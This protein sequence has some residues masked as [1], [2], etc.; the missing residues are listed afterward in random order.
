MKDDSL[1]NRPLI[2]AP[3]GGKASFLGALAAEADAIYCGL[4]HFSARMAAENFTVPELGRLAALAKSRGVRVYIALNTLV[5]P[6][7]IGKAGQLVDQ[8]NR[9]VKPDALIVQ[10]IAFV[11]LAR[12]AGYEGEIHLS[13]LTNVTFPKALSW[14]KKKLNVHRV[15]LPRELSVDEIKAMTAACPSG[16]SVEVFVHGALCYGISGR[17]Y[18]SS[19]LGGKSGLRGRCV[20][21]CRRAYNVGGQKKRYFSCQDFSLDVLAK[22]LLSEKSISAW[23]IEG[24]KKGPHYVFT[25]TQAYR[26][27]RDHAGEPDAKK[28][29]LA[30]LEQ[31]LGRTG[32]HYQ[33]LPQRPQNPVDTSSQTG[34]GLMVGT[35]K[36]GRQSPY[37]KPNVNLLAGDM[38]RLGYEDQEFH[39]TYRVTKSVPRRGN[40]AIRMPA[41]RMPTPGTPVFLIDRREKSV[42]LV[43]QSLS[44][45]LEKIPLPTEEPSR[46]KPAAL[47]RGKK[48][49]VDRNAPEEMTVR[50]NWKRG[51]KTGDALW[52]SPLTAEVPKKEVPPLW[53]WLPP[54][55]WPQD[56]AKTAGLIDAVL[57][58]GAR[59]F[60]LN[61]PWQMDFFQ[62]RRKVIL[63]AGPFCNL[64][65]GLAVNRLGRIG[66]DGA[67]VSPELGQRDYEQL[68]RQTEL[69]LGIVSYGNWPLCVARTLSEDLVPETAFE[70]PRGEHAWIA[71]HESD[72]WLYPNW[73]LDIRQHRG[74]L[75]RSGYRL[76]VHL[77]EPIP[78]GV[79]MKK[80]PG[81]W[82]WRVKLS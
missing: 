79:R 41:N 5:K 81:L 51:C 13:T 1:H 65:N 18:W 27:F 49:L 22:V 67:I 68:A 47:G 50:R 11:E 61:A 20:Q 4:K 39:S 57:K 6:D 8:L 23:K 77:E 7:E 32:T 2:L 63:W 55:V 17:C 24:R 72:Y 10:D 62:Q 58:K 59:R 45:D 14:V 53:W 74:L 56:E 9:M 80:R 3:A 34:S 64:A 54:V 43:M 25:T 26:L 69:P 44:V 73:R 40:L 52:L 78:R 12:Q 70:S 37:V 28:E 38:L 31:A 16:M 46:F 15:V 76:F 35:I 30:L 29:A 82:N 42:E 21:P 75:V 60:V 36:G 71:R 48:V 66:F 33:F 19:F